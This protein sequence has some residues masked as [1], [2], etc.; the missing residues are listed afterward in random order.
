LLSEKRGHKNLVARHLSFARAR[1]LENAGDEIGGKAHELLLLIGSSWGRRAARRQLR[2]SCHS[3][4]RAGPGKRQSAYFPAVF[5]DN[6]SSSQHH[7][8]DS[9]P[10]PANTDFQHFLWY[11]NNAEGR[12]TKN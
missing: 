7:L 3:W 10:L 9:D 8:P 11:Q 5:S 2:G 1:S 12:G 4:G 6:A